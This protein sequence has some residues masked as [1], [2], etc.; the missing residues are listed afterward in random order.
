M[1]I[2][3]GLTV[4]RQPMEKA[5]ISDGLIVGSAG[6]SALDGLQL[7]LGTAALA[8]GLGEDLGAAQ[9]GF[10]VE[11]QLEHAHR[12]LDDAP[13]SGDAEESVVVTALRD[14]LDA[15]RFHVGDA[16]AVPDLGGQAVVGRLVALGQVD[17]ELLHRR[18]DGF[19]VE[20]GLVV[21]AVEHHDLATGAGAAGLV[22]ELGA[23]AAGIVVETVLH[24]AQ[25]GAVDAPASRD[26]E[27]REAVVA[28][29][30]EVDS[31]GR[32]FG[33]RALVH[34]VGGQAV[35][36]HRVGGGE[37]RHRHGADGGGGDRGGGGGDDVGHV[38]SFGFQLRIGF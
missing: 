22:E 11:T 19:H 9:T 10:V 30:D 28:V 24:H 26:V 25:V 2:E 18:V 38:I 33:E 35:L 27:E 29:L 15:H 23:A 8:A 7:H 32:E 4:A 21:V 1:L 34:D 3:N 37:D 31:V 16:L 14:E 20:H 6:E 5:V 12:R 17:R 13:A 36:A